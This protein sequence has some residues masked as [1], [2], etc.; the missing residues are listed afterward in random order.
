M[1]PGRASSPRAPRAAANP[2][3][4]HVAARGCALLFLLALLLDGCG[5]T[6]AGEGPRSYVSEGENEIYHLGW[7]GDGDGP[8]QGSLRATH[9]DEDEYAVGGYEENFVGTAEGDLVTIESQEYGTLRGRVDG[10]T[11]TVS[12]EGDDGIEERA[13]E[14]ASLGEYEE[15]AAE[16]RARK[17]AQADADRALE[18]AA[19]GISDAANSIESYLSSEDAPGYL[20][21]LVSEAEA[22]V[23]EDR[24]RVEEAREVAAM[25]REQIEE[26]KNDVGGFDLCS[27][28]PGSP[29][30]EYLIDVPREEGIVGGQDMYE[31]LDEYVEDA[32]SELDDLDETLEEYPDADRSEAAEAR[33]YAEA[34][35][36]DAEKYIEETN[37]LVPEVNEKTAAAREES[38]R[39]AREW[40]AVL[41]SKDCPHF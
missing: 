26:R 1:M 4:G 13:Y 33:S 15:A 40:E 29:S 30:G 16:F 21:G 12:Y 20:E 39:L 11:L 9:Y 31:D 41:D 5:Q 36:S 6:S 7:D 14:E 17:E 3:N 37:R 19:D 32:R 25:P 27:E 35:I 34:Q 8:V 22:K 23:E 10:D 24:Q 18:E 28:M 38:E 2:R